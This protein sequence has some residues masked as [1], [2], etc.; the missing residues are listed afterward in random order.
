M[1]VAS[2]VAVVDA[3][4]FVAFVMLALP[5]LDADWIAAWTAWRSDWIWPTCDEVRPMLVRMAASSF[6]MA[7]VAALP[8]RVP[9]RIDWR[10]SWSWPTDAWVGFDPTVTVIVEVGLERLERRL[11]G[12]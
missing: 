4:P 9:L 10:S 2:S 7:V 12:R 6:W 11:D 3:S 8:V 5:E 1:I